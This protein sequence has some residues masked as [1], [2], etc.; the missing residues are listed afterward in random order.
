DAGRHAGERRDGAERPAA[1]GE[2]E[3][4]HVVLGAVVVTGECRR[5]QEVDRAVRPDQSA[6]GEGGSRREKDC[7]ARRGDTQGD[8][9]PASGSA[10]PSES[11]KPHR[12][13]LQ[14][15]RPMRSAWLRPMTSGLAMRFPDER[16]PAARSIR[17]SSIP[18]S[19]SVPDPPSV[20]WNTRRTVRSVG[21]EMST[22]AD[23]QLAPT[24]L[25]EPATAQT[26]VRTPASSSRNSFSVSAALPPAWAKV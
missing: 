20:A 3:G 8:P 6:A 21:L 2:L 24:V 9:C 10:V 25:V 22:F 19:I 15:C 26:W 23:C 12:K 5:P 16:Q 11:R 13:A 14:G 17:T 7:Q 1:A 4:G 18:T